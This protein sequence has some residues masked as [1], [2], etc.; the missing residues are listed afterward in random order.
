[1]CVRGAR[2]IDDSAMR[3]SRLVGGVYGGSGTVLIRLGCLGGRM[4]EARLG[5]GGV[6]LWRG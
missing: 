3:G 4:G 6:F 5:R 2:D 1:M